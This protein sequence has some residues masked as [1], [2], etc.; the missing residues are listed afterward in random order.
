MI[1]KKNSEGLI[2]RSSIKSYKS[3]KYSVD[4]FWDF[5][6]KW[7]KGN[8]E[9]PDIKLELNP[10]FQ[11]GH[12]WLP[13][14][15]E[16]YIEHI[17]KGGISGREVYF[18]CPNYMWE[19]KPN[20]DLPHMVCV[21]GLQ[22]ITAVRSFLRGEVKAFGHYVYEY[23]PNLVSSHRYG[24]NVRINDL[25]TKKEVLEWYLELNSGGTVHTDDELNRVRNMLQNC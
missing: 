12:V 19:I 15:Q 16:R 22:R 18:N 1:I 20:C 6:E 13:K 24:F 21:D 2:L 8:E 4:I 10:D 23:E 14:Q 25:Q 17:L 9:D 11:R 7:L 5:L 3:T